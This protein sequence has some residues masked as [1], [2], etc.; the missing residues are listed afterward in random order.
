MVDWV[1]IPAGEYQLGLTDGQIEQ[2]C[3]RLKPTEPGWIFER[4]QAAPLRTFKTKRF[5]IARYPVT[6]VQLKAYQKHLETLPGVDE[7]DH[8]PAQTKWEIANKF[9]EWVGGRLPTAD[10]WQLAAQGP[11]PRLYPWGDEWDPSRGNFTGLPDQPGFPQSA[12]K[13]VWS[14]AT[15]GNAYPSGVSPFGVWD[16][17][18]NLSEWTQTRYYA[19]THPS[20]LYY[21][22]KGYSVWDA[23]ECSLPLW[24]GNLLVNWYPG[25]VDGPA[26]YVGFRPVK[27]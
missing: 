14:R 9:C 20:G 19:P 2:L 4:L 27:E 5:C 6:Y 13:L 22:V 1:E 15:P 12:K 8:F 16:M 7:P 23:K 18:G 24:Y 21:L 25:V 11:T 10:E 3:N 17:A 26:M